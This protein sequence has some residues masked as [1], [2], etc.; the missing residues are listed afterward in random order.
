MKH[1]ISVCMIVRDEQENIEECLR[2]VLPYV[3]EVIV[4]DTGSQDLTPERASA[5]GAQVFHHPWSDDFSTA[6]NAALERATQPLILVLDADER[7]AA[8]TEPQLARFC[9]EQDGVA[10]RVLVRSFLDNVAHSNT[11]SEITRIFPNRPEYRYHGRI[12]EQLLYVGQTP[13]TVST[14]ILITHTGYLSEQQEKHGKIE[15]NLNLLLQEHASNPDD[16]YTI[17]Q[18][19]KTC[20]VG[21]RYSEAKTWFQAAI[22]LVTDTGELPP[23][24]PTLLGQYAYALLHL[25]DYAALFHVVESG[26]DLYADF[27][28]LYFVYG[29]ALIDLKDPQRLPDIRNAFEYC[30]HLGEPDPSRYESVHGV[31]SYIARYNLGVFYEVTGDAAQAR[32]QYRLSADTGYEP[33]KKRLQ[34]LR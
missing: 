31:G 16:A 1:P 14:G 2:S 28:D 5:L 13:V 34:L 6:R 9:R 27:T 30:L 12:H 3:T 8:E 22:D 10:G 33:A 11:T 20:F 32:E 7:F 24:F 15:R 4:V 21:Q 25:Q 29:L 26:I 18:L 19:G 17:Y 23:W